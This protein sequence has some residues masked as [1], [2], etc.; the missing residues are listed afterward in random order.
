V[1]AVK[2]L[3]TKYRMNIKHFIPSDVYIDYTEL[4]ATSPVVNV[5]DEI[6]STILGKPIVEVPLMKTDEPVLK[7]AG[8]STTA[9]AAVAQA[10][11]DIGETDFTAP[12]AAGIA[13]GDI[14]TIGLGTVEE[15]TIVVDSVAEGEV[16][17]TITCTENLTLPIANGATIKEVT[18]DGADSISTDPNNLI[19]AIQNTEMS[20]ETERV[21]SL[22]WKYHWK[23]R[24]DF[25]VEQP[26]AAVLLKNMKIA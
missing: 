20:F 14:L 25:A 15:Q 9:S 4:F 13:A 11:I 7:A 1:K 12:N 3:P 10:A 19:Y 23:M 21:Y 16:T 17:D 6:T 26:E 2:S 5:R 22:G 24:I 8:I 18:L